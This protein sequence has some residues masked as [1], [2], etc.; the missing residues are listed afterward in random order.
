MRA[1]MILLVACKPPVVDSDPPTPDTGDTDVPIPTVVPPPSPAPFGL[2]ARPANPSCVAPAEG[3]QQDA[4]VELTRVFPSVSLSNPVAL[5][6]APGDPSHWYV[7]EQGGVVKRFS[8]AGPTAETVLSLVDLESGGEKG[9]LGIAFPPDFATSG[10]AYLSYTANDGQLHSRLSSFQTSNGGAVWDLDSEVQLMRVDQP[11]GNHNG[12]HIAFGPDG[13]L[14]WGLGD[15]GSGGDPDGNGQDLGTVLGAM[16]RLD[17]AGG[18]AG[19]PS[20]NPFVDTPGA[21]PEIYAYGLRNPW[22]WSFD[23]VN[24][25]LWLGDVGQD[26]WEEIDRIEAGGNYGWRIR[27][28][29]HCFNPDPC[30]PAGLI[31]P[32]VDYAQ[33]V[34]RSVTGG[35]VY[36]GSA[37]PALAGTYL[38]SDFYDGNVYA[39]R[40]DA[41]G[42]ASMEVLVGSSLNITHFAYD[43]NREVY[44]LDRAGGAVYRLDP[45]GTPTPDPFP[46][47]LG[48]TGCFQSADPHE[49]V[50][51]L[52]P[53]SLN[54]PFWSDGAEKQRW[55]AIPEGSSLDVDADGD[56]VFPVGTVLAKAFTLG[57]E[58]TETRLFMQHAE[59]SWAG[60]TYKWRADGSDADLL[61]GADVV[62]TASGPWSIPDRASCVQC[63]TQAAGYA[64]GPELGQLDRAST[65]PSTG[66]LS[67]QLDTLEHIGL[68]TSPLPARTPFPERG[69][70]N[71]SLDDRARTYLHVNCSSCHRPDGPALGELDLR[72]Q[73]ALASTGL[74]APPTQG[75][76]GLQAPQV[77][78]PGDPAN[79]VLWVRMRDPGAYRMPPI[80]SEVVDQDGVDLIGDWI[81][82]LACP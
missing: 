22:R 36:R 2:D 25:D 80:A 33:G 44:V 18:T 46:R 62:Q 16:L 28:G 13:M 9:L 29:A 48:A 15:G 47:T 63:H 37:I 11:Y 71:A 82:G 38:F 66:R 21:R 14:Y 10:L 42:Q 30:S 59:G 27:E 45:A 75:N 24:G 39:V 34:A 41:L 1:W 17:V 20:D 79:S 52:I 58:A 5:T 78:D 26:A 81:T 57:G 77:V 53:Y 49:P 35:L 3:P 56:L 60:Y 74:C 54:H 72:R 55:F 7:I 76:L 23:P 31:D 19:I 61:T 12:G 51:G 69:D 6:Q 70:L 43:A 50:A 4:D 40:Y 67:P 65:Y 64:L 73:T 32:V 68:F 8:A